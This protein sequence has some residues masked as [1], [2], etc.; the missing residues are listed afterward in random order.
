MSACITAR[1]PELVAEA[2]GV[3]K[4]RYGDRCSISRIMPSDRELGTWVGFIDLYPDTGIRAVE[5]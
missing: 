2:Q 3:Y 4:A 1:H 5:S